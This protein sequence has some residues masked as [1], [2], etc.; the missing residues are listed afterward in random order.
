MILRVDQV[1][2]AGGKLFHCLKPSDE[3]RG[4]DGLFTGYDATFGAQLLLNERVR[5]ILL[6]LLKNQMVVKLPMRQIRG[7]I[8]F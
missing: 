6:L 3:V 2:K 7:L 1:N 4:I 5:V 8:G